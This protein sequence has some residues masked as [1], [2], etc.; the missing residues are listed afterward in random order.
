[1][2][3]VSVAE[4]VAIENE[5]DTRGHTYDQMMEHAGKGLA[6]EIHNRYGKLDQRLVLGLVGSGNNGGDTLVA[7]SYLQGWGWKT[8]AYLVRE[9]PAGDPLLQRAKESGCEILEYQ[10]D[11]NLVALETA[12]LTHTV[13]MDG[14]LGTGIRLPLRG[15]VKQVLSRVKTTIEGQ[16]CRIKVVGVDCPSGIDCDSGEIAAEALKANLTITMA[17]IKQGLLKFPAYAWVGDLRCVDIGLPSGL[18]S[19]DRIKREVITK[20]WVNHQIPDRPL[21]AHKSTFGVVMVIAGSLQYSGSVLLAGKAA[22]R[23]GAGWVTLAVPE[24]L[25]SPLAGS[26]LE[27]TWLPLPHQEGWISEKASRVVL[28]NLDRVTTLVLG[29]GFGQ[30]P[31]TKKF[32]DILLEKGEKRLPPMVVDADGLK[33]LAEIP[34]WYERLPDDV[35]LTPHPGEMAVL[36]GESVADILE[37]R[38][39]VAERCAQQWNHVVVLKGAFTVISA[40]GQQTAIIPVATPAL[41]RAGTGDVLAGLI[42]GFRAQGLDAYKAAITGAWVHA[43]AGLRAAR[44]VGSSASVLAG[45]VLGAVSSVMADFKDAAV[46]E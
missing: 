45:D 5:A 6:K 24:I 28:Q 44:I 33:L 39:A 11:E 46:Q 18:E 13:L 10:Q 19:Y 20:D 8:T 37:N 40:P 29:P 16:K 22:F 30:H 32:I 34:R 9:R 31:S 23:S 15:S 14:I 4:M 25:H 38:L 35:V 36:T 43:Q 12:I 17:A 41:A 42:G 1:M 2:K 26:F 7:L 3:Y 27:A 21:D